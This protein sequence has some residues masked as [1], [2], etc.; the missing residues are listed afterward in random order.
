MIKV[1]FDVA[2]SSSVTTLEKFGIGFMRDSGS[3][4]D[5]VFWQ[6]IVAAWQSFQA[7]IVSRNALPDDAERKLSGA[8]IS[9]FN[10]VKD[11]TKLM[12][13]RGQRRIETE[14]REFGKGLTG[15]DGQ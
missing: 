9:V 12:D 4:S 2:S 8:L 10:G 7:K 6:G 15:S 1:V 3:E 5:V 14:L 11:A 13:G